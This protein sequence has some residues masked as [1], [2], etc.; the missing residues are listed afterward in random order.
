MDMI[1]CPA[2]SPSAQVQQLL[3]NALDENDVIASGRYEHVKPVAPF[4]PATTVAP[5]V[6]AKDVE[7]AA[8]AG[9]KLVEP[10]SNYAKVVGMR[11][12]Q[13]E[14]TEA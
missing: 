1:A 7:K 11:E 13:T 6:P 12:I 8:A 10:Q 5:T 4:I 9:H 2:D 3:K 14:S